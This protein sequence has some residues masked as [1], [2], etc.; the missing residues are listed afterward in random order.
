[1]RKLGIVL[2]V[3]GMACLPAGVADA[4]VPG[5]Q[6]TP[7]A[8]GPSRT[9]LHCDG[10]FTIEIEGG[11]GYRFTGPAEP[12]VIEQGAVLLDHAGR[13]RPSQEFQIRTPLAIAAVRGSLMVVDVMPGHTAVF[14]QHGVVAVERRD[15]SHVL[16]L[17]DGEG[18]DV[19]PTRALLVRKRW[20][21]ARVAAL[22]ARFAR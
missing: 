1:M 4:Q 18:V 6:S 12:L 11:S 20:G 16:V 7:A 22:L 10:G 5:C 17:R 15:G 2:A 8:V 9:V 3:I 21:A 13:A 19:V 14:V